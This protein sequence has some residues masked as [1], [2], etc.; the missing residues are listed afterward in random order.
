MSCVFAAWYPVG[1]VLTLPFPAHKDHFTFLATMLPFLCGGTAPS[2][3]QQ[4]RSAGSHPGG[5]PSTPSP[6]GGTLLPHRPVFVQGLVPARVQYLAFVPVKSPA[7]F[8]GHIS[9][10]PRSFQVSALPSWTP[11]AFPSVPVPEL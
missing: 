11:A 10:L 9:G 1:P 7:G 8:P 2:V 6:I 4:H 3:A 5:C